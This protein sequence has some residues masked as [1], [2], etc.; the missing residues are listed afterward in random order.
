M[1]DLWSESIYFYLLADT[2][3]EK[4]EKRK[5][6]QNQTKQTNN[7]NKQTRFQAHKPA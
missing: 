6:Q 2:L 4:K 1:G 3:K 7:N 5:Q